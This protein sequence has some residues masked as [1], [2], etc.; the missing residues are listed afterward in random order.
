MR[1]FVLATVC[2]AI[3][4]LIASN[5]VDA[6]GPFVALKEHGVLQYDIGEWVAKGKMWMPDVPQPIEF[7]GIET[8]TMVGEL[9]SVSDFK[10]NFGGMEFH[11]HGST[12]Y[13]PDT[14]KFEGT[15]FDAMS[16]YMTRMTGTYDEATKTLTMESVGVVP[17]IGEKKGKSTLVHKDENTRVM[18]MFAADPEGGDKMVKEME[19]IY[20]RKK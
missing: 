6:Q 20:T 5:K 19:I 7:E 8:N 13:N 3:I 16:P 9:W 15:W 12:G 17:G 4:S 14:K 2:C 11:G 10:G 1:K 18:T